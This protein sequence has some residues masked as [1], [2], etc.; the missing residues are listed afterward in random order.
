MRV[1]ELF[2]GAGGMALGFH[3]AGW[4]TVA[5]AEW[6]AHAQCVL[7]ARF[8]GVPLYGDVQEMDGREVVASHGP[9]DLVSGGAPCQDLSV[10][11]KRAGLDGSRSVLFYDLVRIW[12]E[13]GAT[14]CLYENV[15]G[16]LSSQKGADFAAV[17]SAFVGRDVPVPVD[18]W[19][20][21]GG[22]V[23]GP[24]GV[25]AWR[26]L[27]AQ[28]FGVPQRRR[29]V[30]VLCARPGGVSPEQVLLEWE[31]GGW[32]PATSSEAG[33]GSARDAAGGAGGGVEVVNIVPA[34]PAS[35][36]GSPRTGNE[37]TEAELVVV[38]EAVT[39]T[40]RGR[41]GSMAVEARQ[42]GI[43]NAIRAPNGGRGGIGC[44]DAVLQ[45][46]AVAFA[47][48]G[49]EDGAQVEVS[50]PV[51]N[52]LRGAAGGSSR[53]YVLPDAVAFHENQ[54]GELR[55]L[56]VFNA[57]AGGGGK[58]GQGYAAV[59]QPVAWD[60]EVNPAPPGLGPTLGRGGLGGRH[61]G[62]LQPEAVAFHP[63]Q[64]PVNG[65]V[66]PSMGVTTGGMGGLPSPIGR[67][68]RLLPIECERLMSWPDSW[69]EVLHLS[70]SHKAK[71]PDFPAVVSEVEE[72]DD[73]GNLIVVEKLTRVPAVVSLDHPRVLSCCGAK[74]KETEMADSHRYKMCGNGVVS[75]VA[76]WIAES[77]LQ[78]EANAEP[79]DGEPMQEAA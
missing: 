2:A 75:H 66:A 13:T 9:V 69:T 37:R 54:R 65:N 20:G 6:D 43:I 33:E 52:A 17:L 35:G 72:E 38:Q 53:D 31:G 58:P 26:V 19:R 46:E 59:V 23:T 12:E 61:D 25:A 77:L 51:V 78:A 36:A 34:L 18:G 24:T 57:L 1:L 62:V 41:G 48:R 63:T 21:G 67:P 44:T 11:G 22:V 29:R 30:F 70:G 55:E 64:T 79:V 28:Y 60:E 42:D 15:L 45:P 5:L 68:R 4:E 14:Y 27:D 47:L 76:Q 16:A 56:P 10:A 74:L 50:G 3:R 73:D 71:C 49:R 7:R 32:H 40:E 39:F 8:P